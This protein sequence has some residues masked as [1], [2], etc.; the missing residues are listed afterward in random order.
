MGN[1]KEWSEA[2]RLEEFTAAKEMLKFLK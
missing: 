1:E 2:K